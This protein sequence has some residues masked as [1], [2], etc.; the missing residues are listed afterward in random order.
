MPRPP[1]YD[2][3]LDAIVPLADV[4]SDLSGWDGAQWGRTLKAADWH[5]LSPALFCHLQAR[6][7]APP[8]VLSA[9]ERG[10]MANAARMLFIREAVDRIVRAL[11][12]AQVPSLL[13]K[14][15]A[16]VESLY[17]DAAQREMLDIDVLVPK[18]QLRSGDAALA[19]LGYRQISAGVPQ[20]GE[21]RHPAQELPHHIPA[22][23]GE[24]QLVAV[25]L[26]HHVAIAGEGSFDMAGFWERSR[27]VPSTGHRIPSPEDLLLHVCFHFT[28]NRLGGSA[29]HRNTGGA[30]GQIA[31]IARIVDGEQLDWDGLAERALAYGLGARVFLALFAARELGV[32]IPRPALTRMWPAGFDR[33]IGRR[34]VDLRVLRAGDHLPV[35]SMR[36]MVAPSREVLSRGWNADPIA[37]LSLARAYLRRAGAHAPAAGSALRRPWVYMQDR[38]LN[39][40]IEALEDRG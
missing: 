17:P 13:L 12:A 20:N 21:R 2:L 8:A 39:D 38:R 18:N 4:R 5:R 15:A 30:L 25:E 7:G 33:E 9:L 28:R 32:A 40:Q 3:L 26:H 34:L 16:L 35:R 37:P 1:E 24:E 10:Y 29:A 19:P 36:W 27:T 6:P 23:V 11:D 31:D 22:L 14:G